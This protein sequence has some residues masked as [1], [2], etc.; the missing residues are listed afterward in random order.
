ML[1]CAPQISNQDLALYLFRRILQVDC[2]ISLMPSLTHRT[3]YTFQVRNQESGSVFVSDRQRA[4][5]VCMCRL[6]VTCTLPV[7]LCVCVC[8][9]VCMCL[10][11]CMCVCMHLE[12][13]CASAA[14]HF[15]GH[16]FGVCCAVVRFEL[17]EINSWL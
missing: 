10:G 15:S 5:C 14:L 8:V 16:K 4:I 7:T 2:C 11:A 17:L 1:W 6:C 13:V 9:C 12:S 3:R